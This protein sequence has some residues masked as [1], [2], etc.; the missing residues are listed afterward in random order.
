MRCHFSPLCPTDRRYIYVA[1]YCGKVFIYDILSGQT[2]KEMPLEKEKNIY[3][4]AVLD[5]KLGAP[6]RDAAWHPDKMEIISTNL[7]GNIYKWYNGNLEE[8][9]DR[10]EAERGEELRTNQRSVFDMFQPDYDDDEG[11]DEIDQEID[12]EELE[13]KDNSQTEET[14]ED[15]GIS[16]IFHDHDE[17]KERQDREDEDRDEEDQEEQQ[18]E[19]KEKEEEEDFQD[20]NQESD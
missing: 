11:I 8:D 17:S 6:M 5:D 3:T 7:K 10:E 4:A 1:S 12:S 2:S 14:Y 20:S 16:S 13:N 9:Q 15:E 19:E 18:D